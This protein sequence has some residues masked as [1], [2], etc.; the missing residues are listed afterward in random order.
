MF[1]QYFDQSPDTL[2]GCSGTY[3]EAIHAPKVR[4]FL[5]NKP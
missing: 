3:I 5:I 4:L 1:A 2:I